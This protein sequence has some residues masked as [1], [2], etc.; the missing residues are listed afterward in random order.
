MLKEAFGDSEAKFIRDM[1]CGRDFEEVK[2]QLT[3]H[4]RCRF[5]SGSNLAGQ[6]QL[7]SG[8]RNFEESQAELS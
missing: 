8:L 6:I 7:K 5:K 4:E 3:K 1:S 2:E